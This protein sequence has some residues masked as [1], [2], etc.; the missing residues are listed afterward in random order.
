MTSVGKGAVTPQARIA[1][2][3]P[4]D[5]RAAFAVLNAKEL[6]RVGVDLT[7]NL[8][9]WIKRHQNQLQL[10]SGIKHAPEVRVFFCH[11]FD[12]PKVSNH[13]KPPK[14]C[15]TSRGNALMFAWKL[16]AAH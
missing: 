11:L 3:R 15:A 4:V 6:I 14:G 12:V 9:A 13:D 2:Q 10:G 5:H 7:A 16:P 8:G 1:Q